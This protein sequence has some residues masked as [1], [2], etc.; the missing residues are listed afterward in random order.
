LFKTKRSSRLSTAWHFSACLFIFLIVTKENR[1]MTI[2]N[3]G[4]I[5]I[6]MGIASFISCKHDAAQPQPDLLF[7]KVRSIIQ[8]NCLGCHSPGGEGMPVVL[9]TDESIVALAEAIKKATVDPVSPMNRRM[10]PTGDLSDEDKNIIS[11]WYSGGGTSH[12]S[13]IH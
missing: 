1:S 3:A 6:G 9:T 4:A 5:I 13:T 10:P 2:R 12:N 8:A 7:P 11:T